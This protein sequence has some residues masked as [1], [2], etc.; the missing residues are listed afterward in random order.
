MTTHYSEDVCC[1]VCGKMSSHIGIASTNAFGSADLDSRPPEMQRS[2]IST[3][4]QRC[5]DCGYCAKRIDSA[6]AVA[7]VVVVSPEYRSQL[8]SQDY[9]ELANAFL[10]QCLVCEK[11]GFYNDAV[12]A[13]VHAAWACDDIPRAEAAARCR[14]E[15]VRL[16]QAMHLRDETLSEQRG[17]DEIMLTDLLRRS[18]RFDEALDFVD[19]AIPT[20]NDE[21]IRVLLL[22]EKG[23]ISKGDT[24]AHKIKETEGG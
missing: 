19:K 1:A 22:F 16:I 6:D 21:F 24:N 3:W 10:C 23:L 13:S 2:T 7:K 11:S 8:T 5:P 20:I 4:V 17:A 9:P 15:A 14:S 12:L 18:G